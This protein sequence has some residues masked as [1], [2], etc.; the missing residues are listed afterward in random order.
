MH[1]VALDGP[2]VGIH[3][4][5]WNLQQAVGQMMTGPLNV[6]LFY[7]SHDLGR[8]QQAHCIGRCCCGLRCLPN[9]GNDD[10]DF[11]QV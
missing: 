1:R 11:N 10:G 2:L 3:L 6:H 5:G 7:S 4:V 9:V 8:L